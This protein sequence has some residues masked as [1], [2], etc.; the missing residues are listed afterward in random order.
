MKGE[1]TMEYKIY[2]CFK[3]ILNELNLDST[4]YEKLIKRIADLL[5]I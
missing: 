5:G 3:V 2:E 4:T 1:N